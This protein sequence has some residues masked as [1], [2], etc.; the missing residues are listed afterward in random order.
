VGAGVPTPPDVWVELLFK[1]IR[2]GV[3]DT[4]PEEEDDEGS[5]PFGINTPNARLGRSSPSTQEERGDVQDLD[6]QVWSPLGG[7]PTKTWAGE[8][9]VVELL[10][11]VFGFDHRESSRNSLIRLRRIDNFLCSMPHY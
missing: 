1:T 11:D 10:K 5:G 3:H 9:P 8:A 7:N 4:P 6:L 2:Y